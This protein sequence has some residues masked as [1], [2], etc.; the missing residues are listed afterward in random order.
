MATCKQLA[1]VLDSACGWTV[2]YDT[3]HLFYAF[4]LYNTEYTREC[5]NTPEGIYTPGRHRISNICNIFS[6]RSK[7]PPQDTYPA[8]AVGYPPP[9]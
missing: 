8:L 4:Q 7:L 6:E 5:V 3:N 2:C 9:V 1:I